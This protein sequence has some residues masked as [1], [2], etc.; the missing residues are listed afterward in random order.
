MLGRGGRDVAQPR[1]LCALESPFQPGG[2]VVGGNAAETFLLHDTVP[3]KDAYQVVSDAHLVIAAVEKASCIRRRCSVQTVSIGST[4]R[5][6]SISEFFMYTCISII[7]DSVHAKS[8][9]FDVQVRD[10]A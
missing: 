7:P 5:R 4:S 2:R 9:F 8:W 6:S 1:R 10:P 3:P